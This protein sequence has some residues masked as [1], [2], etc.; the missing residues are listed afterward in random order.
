MIS[1]LS[2]LL[3]KKMRE[4]LKR[5][6]K[7]INWL[8]ISNAAATSQ[9]TAQATPSP[10]I[11]PQSPSDA[12]LERLRMADFHTCFA[13]LVIL[14]LAT[15][16][17]PATLP[18]DSVATPP[19]N[20][21]LEPPRALW[22]ID[23]LL[24]PLIKGFKYHFQTKRVTN[25]PEKPEWPIHYIKKL[26]KE[27]TTL[28]AS[29]QSSL[30]SSIAACVDVGRAFIA[31]LVATLEAKFANEVPALLDRAESRKLFYHT[32]DE[33]VAFESFLAITYAYPQP[34]SVGVIRSSLPTPFAVFQHPDIFERWL[35][36]EI[37]AAS[38]S[39]NVLANASDRWQPYFREDFADVDAMRPS[40]AAYELVG[41]LRA[42]TDRYS[43]ASDTSLHF[44]FF[45]KIQYDLLYRF[46][47][48]L[49]IM[50]PSDS[51]SWS[52]SSEWDEIHWRE[53]CSV[54][55]SSVYL[56]S[57]LRDWDDQLIF[58][59]IYEYMNTNDTAEDLASSLSAS[60]G[61]PNN[62][63]GDQ[64]YSAFSSLISCYKSVGKAV[65]RKIVDMVYTTFTNRT[66]AYLRRG[67]FAT[68][69][70]NI[71]LSAAA[72]SSSSSPISSPI[73]PSKT[74]DTPKQSNKNN[75]DVKES[76]RS[77]NSSSITGFQEST[78]DISPELTDALSTL[79]YQLGIIL[80][81][82][83]VSKLDSLW[84]KLS[85]AL[86]NHL[87]KLLSESRLKFTF[88]G[89]NVDEQTQTADKMN[90]SISAL[91]TPLCRSGLGLVGNGLF[92]FFQYDTTHDW[93]LP[94]LWAG[95]ILSSLACIYL[96]VSHVVN[97]LPLIKIG[98]PV[99][100]ITFFLMIGELVI[101]VKAKI[102]D[103]KMLVYCNKPVT[104]DQCIPAF[105]QMYCGKYIQSQCNLTDYGFSMMLAGQI[106]IIVTSFLLQF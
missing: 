97:K 16:R 94:V 102:A 21:P 95:A 67:A 7:E 81:S 6:L 77:S 1:D 28:L 64:S 27:Y 10:M 40:N 92:Y 30:G 80:R 101:L 15:Q 20:D 41:M 19:R 68:T 31:G 90:F 88:K 55:N 35:A 74:I 42:L 18:Q 24:E 54:Y 38:D 46:K 8:A 61:V 3:E 53:I 34:A 98:L 91:W 2:T 103:F 83:C 87:F 85:S 25:I 4:E 26:L 62:N 52:R 14:Q 70:S 44:Q 17:Y 11:S 51:Y 12:A 49:H 45:L 73:Q 33:L 58:L 57:V 106:T 82:I 93:K 104:Y 56:T 59:E 29:L 32:M 84:R 37:R 105:G 23:I 69:K 96:A 60:G 39:F 75:E 43:H 5:T 76:N 100:I 79:R 50:V 36:L 47:N 66:Q 65:M 72:K 13:N 63:K 86:D 22:A 78:M 9:A 71:F 48:E 99:V 89:H